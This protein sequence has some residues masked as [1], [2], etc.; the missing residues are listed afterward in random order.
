M[1]A[2]WPSN[3]EWVDCWGLCLRAAKWYLGGIKSWLKN[4]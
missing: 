3:K 1:S 2:L 4:N